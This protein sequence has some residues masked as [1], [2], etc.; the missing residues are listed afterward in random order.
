MGILL[1]IIYPTPYSIYLGGTIG[2]KVFGFLGSDGVARA[3]IF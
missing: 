3:S 1:L 2:H